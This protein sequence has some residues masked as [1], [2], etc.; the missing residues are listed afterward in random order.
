M[1]GF[2]AQN[3]PQQEVKPHV[4]DRATPPEMFGPLDARFGFTVDAAAL[5]HNTKCPV[6]WTPEDD[7]LKQSWAG[8]T[9][10]CNPPFSNLLPWVQKAWRERDA[11]A[12]VMLVPANRTE[13]GWWQDHVE[14]FRDRR[15]NV[16]QVEFVRRRVRFLSPGETEPAANSRPPF[17]VC[18]LIWKWD[19]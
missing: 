8:H 13:Q 7:G 1:V 5:P 18:L 6:F 10:W 2:K 4:D 14:P 11:E 9:V 3:H 12:V 16:L 19:R 17:G 15:G